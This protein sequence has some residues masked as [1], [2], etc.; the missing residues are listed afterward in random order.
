MNKSRVIFTPFMGQFTT[1]I[2]PNLLRIISQL[3]M[4]DV[5]S[6]EKKASAQT[7]FGGNFQTIVMNKELHPP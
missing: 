3:M 6:E 7:L 1:Q 4:P 5:T 2:V